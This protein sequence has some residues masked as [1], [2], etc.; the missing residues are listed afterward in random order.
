MEG[1]SLFTCIHKA[2][3]LPGH[4]GSRFADRRVLK[5]NLSGLID[6]IEGN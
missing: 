2:F 6:L 5:G 4:A 1:R 3:G